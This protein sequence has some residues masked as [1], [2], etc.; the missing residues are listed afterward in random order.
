MFE[1]WYVKEGFSLAGFE[2]WT[3]ARL[4]CQRPAINQMGRQSGGDPRPIRTL[5][6]YLDGAHSPEA[7]RL[8]HIG[9]VQR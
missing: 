5:I 4:V 3:I 9:F 6:F 1:E 2:Q 7:W 8:V